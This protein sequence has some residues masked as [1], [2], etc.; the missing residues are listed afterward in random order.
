[1]AQV[2]ANQSQGLYPGSAARVVIEGDTIVF[3]IPASEFD[4]ELPP[5]RLT[6]FG[7]DGAYSESDRGADITGVDPTEPLQVPSADVHP[8]SP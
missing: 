8:A 1:M 4:I 7:H 2:D 5:Y 3:F 6:S